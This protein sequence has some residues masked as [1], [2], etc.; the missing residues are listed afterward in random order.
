VSGDAVEGE[1]LGDVGNIVGCLL[2]DD[3]RN[4]GTS[5][6]FIE[7]VSVGFTVDLVGTLLDG[8]TVN[9]VGRAD[10]RIVTEGNE[11]VGK[12]VGDVGNNVGTMLGEEG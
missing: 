1:R 4:D 5:V 6:I 2:G 8:L 12:H 10:G 9:F 3:G 11:E 7:G